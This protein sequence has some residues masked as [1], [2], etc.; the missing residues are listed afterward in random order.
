MIRHDIPQ[1]PVTV[2]P[3]AEVKVMVPEQVLSEAQAL[4]EEMSQESE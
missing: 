3:L 1:M 4:L 2:G